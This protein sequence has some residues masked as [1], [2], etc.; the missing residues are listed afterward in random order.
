[1]YGAGSQGFKD[2]HQALADAYANALV[3]VELSKIARRAGV[4]AEVLKLAT[5]R[6]GDV[7]RRAA[8]KRA[9]VVA[10]DG[11]RAAA[12]AA[13]KAVGRTP[14]GALATNSPPPKKKKRKKPASSE[15]ARKQER[16][17]RRRAH[18]CGPRCFCVA[19]AART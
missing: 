12:K 1:V 15:A 7:E 5:Y 11:A 9:A 8:A 10:E 4:A 16:K 2:A 3:L 18:Q 14:L 19:C 13:A 17:R 6:F